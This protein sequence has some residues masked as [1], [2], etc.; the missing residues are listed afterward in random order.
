MDENLLVLAGDCKIFVDVAEIILNL[1]I[2]DDLAFV[3]EGNDVDT[4]VNKFLWLCEQT[5]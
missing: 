4:A 3:A 2:L 1:F 5:S